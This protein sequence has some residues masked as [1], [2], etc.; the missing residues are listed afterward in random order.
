MPIQKI[1]SL[2]LLGLGLVTACGAEADYEAPEEEVVT[3]Q[4]AELGSLC[5]NGRLESGE[6]CDDGNRNNND[7]C[8]NQCRQARCGDRIV[9]PGEQ[10]DDGNTNNNDNCTNSCRV[11]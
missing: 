7:S 8:T 6:Q 4:S 3:E 1:L 5:G 2:T 10:C 11:R 9:G